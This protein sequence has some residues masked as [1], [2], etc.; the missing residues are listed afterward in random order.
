MRP[1]N[2]GLASKPRLDFTDLLELDEG[3]MEVIGLRK[4]EVRRLERCLEEYAAVRAQLEPV[5][6]M[7]LPGSDGCLAVREQEY[8]PQMAAMVSQR[9][10]PNTPSDDSDDGRVMAVR[11]GGLVGRW[12]R[13]G[14]RLTLG[15]AMGRWVS[16]AR[17]RRLS[18]GG[19]MRLSRLK[20]LAEEAAAAAENSEARRVESV[21]QTAHWIVAATF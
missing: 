8:S 14:R 4:L 16:W 10:Q 15:M 7:G 21:R 13:I 9:Q 12:V 5:F 20:A 1:V 11:L 19:T 3:D 2:M 18:V 6:P 17:R